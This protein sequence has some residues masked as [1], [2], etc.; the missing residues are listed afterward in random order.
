[1]EQQRFLI[2]ARLEGFSWK[3]VKLFF[4]SPILLFF[5]RSK[6]FFTPVAFLEHRSQQ[7]SRTREKSPAKACSNSLNYFSWNNKEVGSILP[8]IGLN[9]F[10]YF[11]S[12]ENKSAWRVHTE[13]SSTRSRKEV[14]RINKLLSRSLRVRSWPLVDSEAIWWREKAELVALLFVLMMV[15]D[16]V[17]F[18]RTAE[19]L[20]TPE[21]L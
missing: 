14:N 16:R 7:F 5:F 9:Y 4:R 1:M 8:R 17:R 21:L 20:R 6:E 15:N 3:I 19:T 10:R 11:P 18:L 13:A 12:L 2:V